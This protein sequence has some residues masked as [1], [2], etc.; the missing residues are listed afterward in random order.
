MSQL[1]EIQ[2]YKVKIIEIIDEAPKVKTFRVE[3]FDS[4]EIPFYPGQFFM[5][6][7]E[8]DNRLRRAYSIASSPTQKGFMDITMDIVGKFTTKLFERK[9]GDYLM[10]KGPYGKFY[11]TDSMSNDLVLIGGGLGITPLRSIIRYCSDKKLNNNIK[12]LYSVRTPESI[13]YW[14]ELEKLK[15]ENPNYSFIPTITRPNSENWTG[16]TGRIDETMLKENIEDFDSS[17][18]YL[19]GPLEFVKNIKGMIENLGVGKEQI[20]TDIWGE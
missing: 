10:F 1:S 2:E 20:K 3:I 7:F 6:R 5:V 17:L 8:D 4:V 18:F 12:L 15:E 14:R 13:V 19:C 11:F 9:V 16:R